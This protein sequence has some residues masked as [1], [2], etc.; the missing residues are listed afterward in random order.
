MTERDKQPL[1][2][3]SRRSIFEQRHVTEKRI[4]AARRTYHERSA[5]GWLTIEQ[6]AGN[7]IAAAKDPAIKIPCARLSSVANVLS[8]HRVSIERMAPW[9]IAVHSELLSVPDSEGNIT[10]RKKRR[11]CDEQL[12]KALAVSYVEGLHKPRGFTG[13]WVQAK[14]QW[15]SKINQLLG[16]F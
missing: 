14:K 16:S 3:A 15:K 10:S 2:Y 12:S 4:R 8:L 5:L 9:K 13:D 7:I 6:I 1:P 11:M